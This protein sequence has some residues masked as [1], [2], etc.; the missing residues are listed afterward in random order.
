MMT[1][2][3]AALA[4]LPAVRQPRRRTLSDTQMKG[5]DF[6]ARANR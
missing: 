3:G 5:K 1:F 2:E 4:Q 6:L